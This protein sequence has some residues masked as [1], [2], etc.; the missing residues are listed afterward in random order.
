MSPTLHALV[1]S[2][3]V[4]DALARRWA[5]A[6]VVALPQGLA[7][8]PL[9]DALVDDIAELAASSP[10]LAY[11][12]APPVPDG[13]ALVASEA[14]ATGPLAWLHRDVE[15]TA[16]VLWDGGRVVLGPLEGDDAVDRALRRVGAW[17]RLGE[18]AVDVL[19]LRWATTD[20]LA[21]RGTSRFEHGR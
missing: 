4:V 14:S 20:A 12:S 19:G 18:S 16:A 10:R 2:S 21:Q 5:Q 6:R 1:G 7:L 3:A 13:V 15:A 17:T 9:I 11:A 8:V